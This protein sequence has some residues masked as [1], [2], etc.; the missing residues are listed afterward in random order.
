MNSLS[1]LI[2]AA[3]VVGTLKLLAG[4]GLTLSVLGF[5]LCRQKVLRL[6]R[7]IIV[8]WMVCPENQFGLRFS[9]VH[10]SLLSFRLNAPST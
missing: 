5:L 8:Q 2:Y 9:S 3:E 1:I 7:M 6:F 10:H 4:L